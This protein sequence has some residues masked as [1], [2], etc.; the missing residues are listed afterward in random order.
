MLANNKIIIIS[1]ASG[2]GK[3]TIV[4]YLLS[5]PELNLVFSISACTREKRLLETDNKNYQFLSDKEFKKKIKSGDFLEWE[6][7]YSGCFY[8]TLKHDTIALLNSGKNIL[9]DLDVCGAQKIKQHFTDKAISI[10]IQAPSIAIAKKRLINRKTESSNTLRVRLGKIADE[11]K[12]GKMMDFQIVNDDLDKSKQ[13][14]Y[15]VVLSF[16]NQ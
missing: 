9:F 12:I 14:I 10:F 13:N 8:G 5:C 11:V 2:A 6:E 16:L 1:G 15:N 7:V 3:T 4:D